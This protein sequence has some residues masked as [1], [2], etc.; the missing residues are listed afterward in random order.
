[1]EISLQRI[2]LL[3]RK[4]WV[5]HQKMY[6]L[7][8]LAMAGIISVMLLILTFPNIDRNGLDKNTQALIFLFGL[9]FFGAIF[10]ATLFDQFAEKPKGIQALML[11]ASSLEKLLVP[12]LFSNLLFP[13]IYILLIYPIVV[14]A[15]Y[16][17][18]HL[19]G[20][21]NLLICI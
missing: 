1:M 14:F 20:N 21:I 12:I 2:W 3:F 6:G 16:V 19:Q 9:V 18:V 13:L 10:T 4:Q 11:P 15:H 7:G 17:D 5:D 8:L